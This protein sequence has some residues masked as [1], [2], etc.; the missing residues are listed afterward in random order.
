MGWNRVLEVQL[1]LIFKLAS[2][3]LVSGDHFNKLNAFPLNYMTLLMLGYML[4]DFLC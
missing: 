2:V 1:G 3:L 4:V